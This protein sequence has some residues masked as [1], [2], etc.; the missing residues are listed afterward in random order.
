MVTYIASL[1]AA[2]QGWS[3]SKVLVL[4]FT[5]GFGGWDTEYLVVEGMG[6]VEGSVSLT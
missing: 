5:Y 1:K 6:D 2:L 4:G 3:H